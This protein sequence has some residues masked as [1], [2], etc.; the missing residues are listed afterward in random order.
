[1]PGRTFSSPAD[2]N[3]QFGQWLQRANG[4]EVR[5]IKARPVDLIEHDRARMLPLPPVPLLLGWHER[6]RLGRDYYVR[7]DASDYSVDPVAI[8]RMVDV[9]ADLDRV[10]VRVDGKVIADH[11]RVWARGTAVPNNLLDLA[12]DGELPTDKVKERLNHI[13]QQRS[14]VDERLASVAADLTTGAEVL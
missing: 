7:L 2:F 4:R 14:A 11:E 13:R 3:T 12:A 9:A 10:H 1:M 8:G 5:T 6:V